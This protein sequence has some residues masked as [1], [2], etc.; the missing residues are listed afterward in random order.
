MEVFII[1]DA[2]IPVT[3]TYFNLHCILCVRAYAIV[4][5]TVFAVVVVVVVACCCAHC[6]FS[7]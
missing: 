5:I 6:V 7:V 3:T 1:A 2:Q 4:V